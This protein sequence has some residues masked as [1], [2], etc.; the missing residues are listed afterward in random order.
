MSTI[1]NENL[2]LAI[3][4]APLAGSLIA[5]LFGKAVGRAGAHSVTILGVAISFVLSMMVFFQVLDGAS[6]NATVYEWMAIGKTKFEVGF[7]VDSL[8]AMMM[9]VVT[10]V[11]LMVHIYTI[12]YM[13][14][15][16]G[17]QRFFSYISLFTFSM[18]MLVMSN[19]F[20]QLF[21]GW[22]AVGLVSYLLIGFYFT[23]QSAV[24]ANMKA[25]IVNRIGDFGFLLGIGLLFA[26]AGSMNY[27]DVFA[28][29]TEL[30][31]LSFPGTDWGLLTVACICLFIGA[32][33]KSAQFP[34]HVWLPDSMEG[35][36]PISALIHA[37]TMVTAGIFM[38][39]RMSPLFE[40]SDTAL[41]FVMVIGAITALFMGFLGIVQNDIKR[42]VA[43]ST[44]SQ[45]GYMTV[46]LGASAYSVAVFHLMTH[47]FFKALLFLGAGSVIIGMHHD[48]DM[49][50]MG[51]LRK[52]MP[53][54]WITSLVG[55]LALI[56]TPFFSG[57][58][59]KDS[60]IDAVKL[61]HL[62]GSGFAYFAVVASVFVTALYS[63]RMYFMVFHGKER[64]RDP[65]H[66]D[67]PMGAEAA[68]HAH[69]NGHDAHGHGHDDHGHAHEPH[70]TP[71]VVWVPLV[72]LAIPSVVIGA[73]AIGPML[74]GD[75][76]QHGVAFDKVIFIGENHPALHE[77][78]EEFHGW[79]AMGL[80][81]V[82]GLPV[83][84]ALAGVVVA[85]FLYLVRPDLP[86]TIKRAFGPIYTLLDNKYYMDKINEV[87]FA[88][89]AVAIGRGLWKEGDVV[90][91]DGIVNGSARFIGWFAGVIRFLQSGYIYHYAFAMIIGMLGL[92]T[93]FVTLGGK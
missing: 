5:G 31:A 17:Y 26:F 37:A 47:A 56:G 43:Y 46:A 75:F 27:G 69:G 4:L 78:A 68:A 77:M 52:Y 67:S 53:I 42:V 81:S 18:L 87:V 50:N 35:P 49:R 63:F 76:F 57:F 41:S 79:A 38:V 66:P 36:T 93:L 6:F 60:I 15:D 82:A 62:P 11:S 71:W 2:L 84:L 64:F 40:L 33:G 48:Q 21:F 10:F 23:R 58:Y 8:T 1:L 61:S 45:L 55:S 34:L 65:K 3:P 24:Y 91:I 29:R 32:M 12:G 14:D 70:E 30:A 89:G 80:H 19:N 72:L 88:R 83:W 86:A 90:V 39:T 85:W 16:D 13:A 59:S 25:F 73:I 92:L 44:L 51:G 74:F 22:E 7:L 9:C 28:K 20:L 54:T